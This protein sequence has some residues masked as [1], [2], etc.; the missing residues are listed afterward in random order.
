M[1]PWNLVGGPNEYTATPDAADIDV[2][3]RWEIARNAD[4]RTVRIE[5]AG[6]RLGLESLPEE[7]RAAIRDRG[8]S[9]LTRYLGDDE[10]P[11]RIV[12]HSLGIT[13][14]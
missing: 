10:P 5:V 9:A 7:C 2:G 13:A 8:R 3:W 11:R 6:G 1:Q 14:Q 12:I 4:R